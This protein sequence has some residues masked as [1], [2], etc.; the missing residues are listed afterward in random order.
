[1]VEINAVFPSK[2]PLSLNN[3]CQRRLRGFWIK[4]GE[5]FIPAQKNPSA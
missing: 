3:L 2:A 5:N 1:M 4:A